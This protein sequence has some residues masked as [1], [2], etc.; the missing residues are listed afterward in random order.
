MTKEQ[1]NNERDYCAMI[2]LAKTMLAQGV[3]NEQDFT[4]LEHKLSE[5][6]KPVASCL[7]EDGGAP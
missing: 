3:I 5:Q 4:A 6:Y 2:A 1:F 7:Q